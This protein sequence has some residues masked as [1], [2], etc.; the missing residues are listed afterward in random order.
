M[1]PRDFGSFSRRARWGRGFAKR[2]F[3][4]AGIPQRSEAGRAPTESCHGPPRVSEER[5]SLRSCTSDCPG[6]RRGPPGRVGVEHARPAPRRRPRG[7][8][9]P[10]PRDLAGLAGISPPCLG[11]FRA[12]HDPQN[13]SRRTEVPVAE[14]LRPK[15]LTPCAPCPALCH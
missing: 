2:S 13:L 6:G 4:L 11:Q 15:L 3:A 12:T 1:T 8:L 14:A 10:R 9:A 7:P 5:P